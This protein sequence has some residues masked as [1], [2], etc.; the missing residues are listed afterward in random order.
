[1][2]VTLNFML[3]FDTFCTLNVFSAFSPSTTPPMF[4]KPLSGISFTS[5]RTPF[6]INFAETHVVLHFIFR[7]SSK[8]L[9]FI[10][11]FL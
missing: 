5:G 2:D 4:N 11:Y 10:F 6:P 3:K 9:S 8:G 1:M 7:V